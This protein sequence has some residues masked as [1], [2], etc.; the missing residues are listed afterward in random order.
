[1]EIENVKC[2]IRIKSLKKL[3][4]ESEQ[5]LPGNEYAFEYLLKLADKFNV[6]CKITKDLDN[7]IC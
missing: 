6:K 4:E 7:N 2:P 1:M 3:L 5:Y